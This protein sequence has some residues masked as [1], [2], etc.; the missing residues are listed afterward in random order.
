[1]TGKVKKVND[2][3]Y[4]EVDVN[5]SKVVY[6]ILKS[7]V[8][9]LDGVT[10]NF[11]FADEFTNPDLFGN[12]SWGDSVKSVIVTSFINGVKETTNKLTYDI[13]YDFI[14]MM[15]IRMQ[16][17]KNKYPIGNWKK[18]IDVEELK[19]ALFRHIMEIMQGNYDDEQ[20][21][22]HLVAVA[23]NAF[24]ITYQLKN[25]DSVTVNK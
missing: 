21:Y 22:G 23:C 18:K 15:A 25:A 14:Q 1:M 24:M 3:N 5:G 13:D 4:F 16:K 20:Y 11:S 19:Q 2:V 10:Y 9:L 12:V 7:N 6:P 8:M 17:N